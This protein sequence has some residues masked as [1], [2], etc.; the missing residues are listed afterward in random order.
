MKA[1]AVELM[2]E[3]AEGHDVAMCWQ[4]GRLAACLRL[5]EQVREKWLEILVAMTAVEVAC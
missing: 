3:Q 1:L 4:V 2:A 5:E